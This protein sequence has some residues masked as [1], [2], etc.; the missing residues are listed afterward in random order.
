MNCYDFE[1]SPFYSGRW[2]VFKGNSDD[3]WGTLNISPSGIK[4]NVMYKD[5]GY[6]I[7]KKD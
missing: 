5:K 7:D 6:R 2:K 1:F 4:L 3:C